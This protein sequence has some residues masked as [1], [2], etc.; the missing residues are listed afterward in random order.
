MQEQLDRIEMKLA[1]LEGKVDAAYES[2]EKVRKYL[3][4]G[5]WLTLAVI[6]IPLLILPTLLGPF[7]SAVGGGGS[8]PGF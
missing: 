3:V 4:W 6:L 5:F 8:L 1:E 7:M 2:Q